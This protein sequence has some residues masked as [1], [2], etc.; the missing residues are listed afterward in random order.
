[1]NEVQVIGYLLSTD[2]INEADV[3]MVNGASAALMISDIPWNGPIGCIRLGEINGEFV[4]NPTNEQMYDSSLDL[5]YVGSEK[6]MMMIEGSADQMP[7]DRFVEA[8]EFAHEQIQDIISAQCKLAE[9]CGKEKKNFELVQTPDEILAL[10]KEITGDRLEDAI[11]A[12]SKQE[13]QEAVDVIKEEAISAC[14][15]KFGEEF[16]PDHVKMAFEILQEE[17][18]RENILVRGKRADG[19][20][21]ADLREISCET[22]VLP[23]VHGSAIF[24]RG[25]TQSLVMSTLGTSRDVQELD[26]LTGGPTAKSFILHYNFPPFSVGEAGRFGF[27]SRREMGHGALAERSVLPVLPAEDDFPYAIR[28]VSEIMSSNGSTSMASVC[29]GSLALMDAGV[30]ISQHVA[31][32]STGLVTEMDDDGNITKHVVLTDII[33]A[34]DHFGDMDFKVCGTKDG[35]TGF[36]LDLK[37]QGLPFDIAKEAVKQVTEAR[38][39]ILESMDACLPT[40]RTELRD[41]APRIEIV[42]IDPEKIGALIGPGGKNI[43]RITEVTGANLDIDEDNSGKV[44]VYANDSETMKRALQEIDLVTGEIEVGKTYRGIVRGVKEFGAFVE[45]LP[46]KEGLCHISELADFRVNKTEDICKLGDEIIVKCIG[47]DDKGRV[48]LSR[49]AAMEDSKPEDNASTDN[50]S[51]D[52]K[53]EGNAESDNT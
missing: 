52:N 1:M 2:Q 23:R 31:G 19:R 5:I 24:T 29:G 3:L 8:L 38:L 13:R 44:R 9:L 7:E 50:D 21:P 39:K 6:E 28:V 37:I 41:H 42:Q 11:F 27:T 15:E 46:G 26:G 25:E 49:R 18:Y 17:V 53:S 32:I 22:G 40:H 20:Q 43:R 33:G 48:K 35:V 45:C 10:C 36:Q 51:S 30:P 12:D 14:E 16:N 47:I 4:V 34:E